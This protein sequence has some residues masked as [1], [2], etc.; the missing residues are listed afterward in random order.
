MNKGA[1]FIRTFYGVHGGKYSKLRSW[2]PQQA[3]DFIHIE[4]ACVAPG[5]HLVFSRII[6]SMFGSANP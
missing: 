5:P 1:S 6:R 3:T 2:L 4:V